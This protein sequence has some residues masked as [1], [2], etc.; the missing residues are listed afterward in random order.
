MHCLEEDKE[1]RHRKK[2]DHEIFEV[3]R[4]CKRWTVCGNI[5]WTLEH[6]TCSNYV[7]IECHT[8]N[9][10]H[11]RSNVLESEKILIKILITSGKLDG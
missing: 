1:E 8:Q 9:F 6:M 7:I 10:E 3:S 5:W 11:G 4:A 2:T